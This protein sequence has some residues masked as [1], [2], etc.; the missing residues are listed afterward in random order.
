MGK[1]KGG[2]TLFQEF[3]KNNIN[4]LNNEINL[5]IKDYPQI[6]SLESITLTSKNRSRSY[7]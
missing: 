5:L 4:E 3:I 1:S 7:F 6:N 2:T